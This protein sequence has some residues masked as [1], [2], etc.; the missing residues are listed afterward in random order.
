MSRSSSYEAAKEAYNRAISAGSTA[1]AA[2]TAAQQAAASVT[3]LSDQVISRGVQL[4]TN[5]SAMLGDNSNFGSWTYDPVEA[6]LGSN[7]S[8]KRTSAGTIRID[9]L[10]ALTGGVDYLLEFDMKSMNG[11]ITAYAMLRFFDVDKRE[12]TCGNNMYRPNTTTTLTQD[13]KPGDTVV[14][15]ADLTNWDVNTGSLT[16]RR[17]FIIWNYKNSYG[18]SYPAGTLSR[19]YRG[20]LYTDANVNKSAKTITLTSAWTGSTVPAGTYISQTDSGSTYKYIALVGSRIPNTWTHYSG[21]LHGEID[22]SGQNVSN[23]LPPGAAYCTVGFLW[24]YNN[25]SDT[26]WITNL[27]LKQDYKTAIDTAQSTAN[28]A[29]STASSAQ[30][31]ANNA[32]T[33]ANGAQTTANNAQVAA[34]NAQ[35]TADTAVGTAQANRREIDRLDGNVSGL[36]TQFNVFASGIETTIED[37]NE[38]LSA[39]SFSIEGLKVQMAGSIYYTLTDDV[40]YHI[41][42]NNKEIAAF[43]EG[44]GSME[45]LQMGGIICRKTSKGG[46][47]WAEGT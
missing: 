27:S 23:K 44:K 24:N 31:A 34:V 8:F 43:S 40:G 26:L 21:V 35:N 15:F 13:L 28:T 7:G 9:E 38:I 41:Y 2:Q 29:Q 14:H 22:L 30:T 5:G 33:A 1:A 32:Q 25:A 19:D 16:Y 47:V 17:G 18:Y 42:Q 11:L 46:W 6:N 39:M 4:I 10:I 36:S 20:N 3:A 45:Q 12:I 37:H